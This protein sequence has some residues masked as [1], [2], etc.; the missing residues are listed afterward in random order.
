M[1]KT[2]SQTLLNTSISKPQA[3]INTRVNE[4]QALLIDTHA[5]LTW[6][7]FQPDLD[8]VVKRA[9]EA[10]VTKI[11]NVGAD[12]EGSLE[13]ADLECPGI[14]CYST[15]G[16]HP[17]ETSRLTTDQAIR[18]ALEKL[19]Q[20]YLSHPQKVVA[21][22]E[23]GLDYH[24]DHNP[25]LSPTDLS[26]KELIKQQKELFLSQIQLAK[27]LNLPLVIHNREAWADIFV[28]EF[29]NTTGVFHSFSGTPEQAQKVLDLGYY[30]GFTCTVTYPKNDL[31]REIIKQA[32]L[33][34]ILTETDCP[35]LPPQT[36]R[37]QRNE[38]ANV[39]EVVKVI[40][41]VKEISLA[42][43]SE[44]TFNNAHQLFKLV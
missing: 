1:L 32:P 27:K 40:A 6:D 10:G 21:V 9:Q 13:A 12:L 20:I 29:D 39:L 24:F 11:I 8:Q 19:E 42:E 28:P 3:L 7:S 2:K 5:H 34:R 17:H 43:V 22:G 41:A 25:D 23:T 26:E 37:G 14:K 4:Y 38:P 36:M 30:L 35:F 16:L 18:Q 44:A 31:L 33:E 15:I